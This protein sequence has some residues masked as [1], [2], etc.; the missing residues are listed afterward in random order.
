MFDSIY[1]ECPVCEKEIEFQS[2]SGRC[3]LESCRDDVVPLIIAIGCDNDI[4]QCKNCENNFKI[5]FEM[6]NMN[7][8]Y[9]L[10]LTKEEELY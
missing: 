3:V 7:V 4:V 8:K 10:K 2:K 9:K 5:I 6:P 1:A